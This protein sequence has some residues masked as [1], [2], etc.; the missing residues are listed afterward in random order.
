MSRRDSWWGWWALASV[1]VAVTFVGC[2]GQGPRSS[3]TTDN[4]GP[5]GVATDDGA[6]AIQLVKGNEDDLQKQLD[7][8]KGK[9]VLVDFWA[10]WCGPCVENFPHTVELYN[11]HHDEGLQA[12]TVS[13]DSLDEEAGVRKFLAEHN[14]APLDNFLSTYGELNQEAANGFDFEGAIPHYRL[15]DRKGELRYKWNGHPDDLEEKV[16]E[17]LAEK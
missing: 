10:T 4:A 5:K 14:A 6:S 17:L 9:V 1:A 7:Q 3:A 13:F 15:Y 12:I 8:Y 16:N 11:K 2:T